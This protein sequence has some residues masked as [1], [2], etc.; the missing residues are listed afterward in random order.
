MPKLSKDATNPHFRSRYS[1][2]SNV[3]DTCE[4]ALAKHGLI[5]LQTPVGGEARL[6]MVTT[7][8]HT[9]SGEWLQAS[10]PLPND[11]GHPQLMGSAIS[12]ARRYCYLAVVGITPDDDDDA[13]AASG[14][15]QELPARSP[16][17]SPARNGDTKTKTDWRGSRQEVPAAARA[18]APAAAQT[19]ERPPRTGP[20]LYR[21]IMQQQEER[22]V[23]LLEH[24]AAFGKDHGFPGKITAYS[25]AMVKHAHAE[26]TAALTLIYSAADPDDDALS[27]EEATGDDGRWDSPQES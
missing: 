24:V 1:T 5:V 11:P 12:Y 8:V 10:L 18:T 6:A 2:L 7:L 23:G 9:S 4:D 26:A 3:L 21:W 16:A 20:E 22:G 14:R 25:P 27:Y 19:G 15:G 13:E 17:P